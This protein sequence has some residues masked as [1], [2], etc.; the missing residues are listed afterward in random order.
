M[1]IIASNV[2]LSRVI[3][4]S[5]SLSYSHRQTHKRDGWCKLRQT[6]LNVIFLVN[7][8][9]QWSKYLRCI[10]KPNPFSSSL[11]HA[12]TVY[13]S[14]PASLIVFFR[15]IFGFFTS[16]CCTCYSCFAVKILILQS[17]HVDGFRPITFIFL[18]ASAPARQLFPDTCQEAIITTF[19][20]TL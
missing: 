10:I 6:F 15:Y 8:E 5:F 9:E 11:L 3:S 14:P 13:F 20:K 19:Y 17:F 4:L 1:R 18:G 16:T 7:S 2:N 12:S